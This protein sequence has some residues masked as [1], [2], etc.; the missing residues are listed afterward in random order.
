MR[1]RII[2]YDEF[3]FS[4]NRTLDYIL[5]D[6][7][8]SVVNVFTTPGILDQGQTKKLPSSDKLLE[9]PSVDQTGDCHSPSSSPHSLFMDASDGP[10]PNEDFPSD[11][12]AIHATIRLL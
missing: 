3:Y 12:I 8:C 2:S 1:N 10:F 5:H 11:H 6:S 7:K 9:Y 4:L